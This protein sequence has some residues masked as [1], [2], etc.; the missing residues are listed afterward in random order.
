MG[1]THEGVVKRLKGIKGYR[2]QFKKVFGTED[3]TIDHVAMAIASYER[4]I[5]S[6]NSPFDKYQAGDKTAL[7]EAAQRGLALF[8]GKANCFRCHTGF[9]FTDE[10]FHNIGVGWDSEKKEFKDT[11]RYQVTKEQGDKGAFKTPTLRN[12]AQT[13]PYMHDGSEKTL[14]DVVEYYDRGGTPNPYLA[15]EVKPLNLTAEEKKDLVAFLRSLT[16]EIPKAA[17]TEPTSFPQ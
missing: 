4:T 9:N 13:A 14:E 10:G 12:I 6:G 3:L 2:D 15:A 1:F 8:N 5:L 11:G 17:V 7:S 16:G